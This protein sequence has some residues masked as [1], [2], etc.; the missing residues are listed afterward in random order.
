M[1]PDETEGVRASGFCTK[2][3]RLFLWTGSFLVV[4]AFFF[5]AEDLGVTVEE[6]LDA[7]DFFGG[8]RIDH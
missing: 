3:S 4:R 1:V 6:S 8:N 7:A 2:P 5:F